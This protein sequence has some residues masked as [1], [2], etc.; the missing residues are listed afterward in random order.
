[1]R[2]QA[3]LAVCLYPEVTVGRSTRLFWDFGCLILDKQ[4]HT[5]QA[6]A[7]DRQ[8]WQREPG[9]GSC[10]PGPQVL[11]GKSPMWSMFLPAPECHPPT[12]RGDRH[13][14]PSAKP[15]C[16]GHH[17]SSHQAWCPG[18]RQHFAMSL[19]PFPTE[20][21]DSFHLTVNLCRADTSS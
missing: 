3:S 13:P 12:R 6:A 1:M 2:K 4:R 16:R 18:S 19:A 9:E 21:W 20:G 10:T 14:P 15:V 7:R 8:C 17:I 11:L 5:G